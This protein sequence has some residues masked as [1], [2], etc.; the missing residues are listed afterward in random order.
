MDV[1]MW[2]GFLLINLLFSIVILAM[3]V[4]LFQRF[5]SFEKGITPA[6]AAVAG[7][8][9][10][11]K[12]NIEDHRLAPLKTAS[13][14]LLYG[15][16]NARISLVEYG[17]IECP[18]CR[19]MHQELKTVIEHSEGTVNWEFKHFPLSRHNP[20]AANQS[21]A[22]ECI[23]ENYDN[24]T[25][26]MALDEFMNKTGGN[27]RGVGDIS[28]FTHAL[29]LNGAKIKNCMDDGTLKEKINSDYASGIDAGINATPAIIVKDNQSNKKYLIKGYKNKEL[30]LI[31]IQK[32]LSMP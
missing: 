15:N 25:A 2:R 10:E 13:N 18:F 32:V 26:W 30:L 29:G 31:A 14:T 23:R 20:T 16:I 7:K 17:D 4:T 22:I 1:K 9:D 27:G 19:K 6:A 12:L 3:Q 5:Y 8:H 28:E 21:L 11:V 24:R